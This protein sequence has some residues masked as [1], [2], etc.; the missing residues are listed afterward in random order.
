MFESLGGLK[1][2]DSYSKATGV[3]GV[4]KQVLL[5]IAIYVWRELPTF[6]SIANWEKKIQTS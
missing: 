6:N 2:C 5:E 4:W 3:C 1:H